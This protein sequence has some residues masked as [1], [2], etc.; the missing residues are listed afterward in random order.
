MQNQGF[1]PALDGLIYEGDVVFGSAGHKLGS[2]I[3][4]H[5]AKVPTIPCSHFAVES[6]VLSWAKSSPYTVYTVLFISAT[7]SVEQ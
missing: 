4:L 6:S 1:C 3:L 2:L 5:F 7:A